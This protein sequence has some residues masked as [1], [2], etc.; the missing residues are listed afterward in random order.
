MGETRSRVRR[1]LRLGGAIIVFLMLAGATYQ[2][3]ATALERREFPHPGGLVS[4]GDHQ[5]H[6][7]C[8]GNGAPTVVLEAPAAALS[9][10]WNDVQKRVA[11]TTRVCSYDRSG[12]GWSEAGDRPYDPGRVSEELRALLRTAREPGP[13]IVAGHGL[14]ATFARMYVGRADADAAALIAIDPPAA[15]GASDARS[16]WIMPAAPWL[17][18][19]G[20]LRAT[21]ML[22]SRADAL[23]DA[24]GA[25]M[26]SFLNRPDHLTRAAAEAARWDDTVRLAERVAV[27][28]PVTTITVEA[29][30][31]EYT[32]FLT[33]AGDRDRVVSAI[34]AA[35][36][37]W[38]QK[39]RP[40]T[41]PPHSATH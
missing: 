12:L 26:R 41:P 18:R 1:I 29:D 6:L 19:V 23:G 30:G 31:R 27:T 40:A 39:S 38:R 32:S 16:S 33:H 7:F 14:G 35:V 15:D 28:V 25:A 3:I 20:L 5:L 13:F 37:Q 10:A 4:V 24:S 2:G 17:A 22:S 21:R 8:D 34:D 36:R 11:R 9:A